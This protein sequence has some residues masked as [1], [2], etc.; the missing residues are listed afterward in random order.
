[1]QGFLVVLGVGLVLFALAALADRRSARRA[2]Q[3][4][5]L[6]PARTVAPARSEPDEEQR[7][8]LEL[9]RAEQPSLA[10]GLA[11]ASMATWRS[12]DCL[13]LADAA[14]LCCPEGIGSQRELL[15]ARIAARALSRSLLVALTSIPDDELAL[16]CATPGL[17]MPVLV[18]DEDACRQLAELAGATPIGRG[19]LQAGLAGRALGHVARLVA[20]ETA[21]WVLSPQPQG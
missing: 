20:D 2:Q 5:G 17:T 11:D 18:G 16:L 13:E 1:M 7:R 3:V 15:N 14:V 19:D 9:F 6:P 21:C 12:P 8:A 10:L 4:V